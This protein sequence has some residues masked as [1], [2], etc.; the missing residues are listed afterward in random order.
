MESAMKKFNASSTG[1]KIGMILFA[2]FCVFLAYSLMNRKD[3]IA[4]QEEK[5]RKITT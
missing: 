5:E 4:V 2:L 1:F 3:L